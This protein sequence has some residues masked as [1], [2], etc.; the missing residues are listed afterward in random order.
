MAK[1]NFEFK[2]KIVQEH[3]SGEGGVAFLSKNIVFL[4]KE[5]CENGLPYIMSLER[6]D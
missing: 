2:M 3:L 4:L 6:M 5:T 1:Y